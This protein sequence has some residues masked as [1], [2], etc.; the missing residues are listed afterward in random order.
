[1]LPY[2]PDDTPD[3]DLEPDDEDSA[4]AIP[5]SVV[6][7][8]SLRLGGRRPAARARG[9]RRSSTRPTSR[10]SP[11]AT[12][13]CARTCAAPTPGWPPR[14]RSAYLKRLG[15]TAVELLPIHHIADESFLHERGLT[16]LLGL[17]LDRLP[18]AALRVRRHRAPRRAGA[19]VQ[20][21][22][23]GA[24]PRG[25]RGD[26]RRRLQPHRRG[27]P[28]RP[29][30]VLQGRRQRELLP[31]GARRP[32][33]LHGLHGHGQHARR[34]PPERP[35]ADHG[36]AALLGQRVPRRRLPLRPRQRAG[37]RALR[38]RPPERVLRH[39][40]PGPDPVAGQAHRR[41]V[42]RRPRRLPG[43]QLPGPVERVERHLPRRRARLLAR[44]VERRRVRLA[45]HRLERPLRVRRAPAVRLDQLR[46]RPRRLHAA[47]PRHLQREAQ[48]GQRR[49]QPRR[50]RRQPLVELRRR[51]RD[52][53]PRDRRAA[54]A[55]A[56]QL[57]GHAAALAGRADAARR[58]R[59]RAAPSTAT[60]TPGART[61]RSPG[62]SGACARARA[63]TSTSPSA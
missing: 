28:P 14:R 38:R 33:P 57:P 51:G 35:A 23:Q 22:G 49:G 3:A 20:G 52:R 61:T 54:L 6:V 5:K 18:R 63:S 42:G 19:R 34:P 44:A 55:P 25:H 37:A 32:A 30:A 31:P 27:Q 58:R 41:A 13:P 45:L 15:V 1:M 12:P 9:T 29:D 8:R 40:P 26:P 10:A 7:D 36:L 39:H 46:H 4:P 11:S 48:R 60:T 24:A 53:R 16:Q 62:T 47:R 56:A 17:Q 59:A 43:R 2:T 21:H 50:H